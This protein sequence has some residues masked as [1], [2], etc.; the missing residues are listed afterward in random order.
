MN[1]L[2]GKMTTACEYPESCSLWL[3]AL[4]YVSGMRNCQS[5]AQHGIE[6][7]SMNE[8]DILVWF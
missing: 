5:D 6:T 8:T 3:C 4:R 2:F 7:D 1:E